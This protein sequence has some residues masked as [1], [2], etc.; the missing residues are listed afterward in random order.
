[1]AYT[2]VAGKKYLREKQKYQVF[3]KKNKLFKR[4]SEGQIFAKKKTK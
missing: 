1:M 4:S 3:E 2:S